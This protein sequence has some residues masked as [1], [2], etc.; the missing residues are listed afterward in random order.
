MQLLD[1]SLI[2]MSEAAKELPGRPH[3]ATIHRYA[4]KGV[5]GHLL[6]TVAC[7]GRIYTSREA[8]R[9]FLAAQ[10]QTSRNPGNGGFSNPQRREQERVARE[11]DAL[12]L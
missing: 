6:E 8:C 10:N 2:S 11:L 5:R 7:G 12:G 1:E 9:R 3:I 4:R